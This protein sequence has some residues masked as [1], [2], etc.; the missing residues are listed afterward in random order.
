MQAFVTGGTGFVGA[1]LVEALTA[2]G[3]GARIL[4]RPR[5]TTTALAGLEYDEATGDILDPPDQLARLMEGCDWLFHAAAVADYWRQDKERLYRVNVGGV[6]NILQAARLAGVKRV[7]LTS[8]LASLGL[9]E[10]GRLLDESCQFNLRPDQFPYGHS[11][12]LAELEARQA[13]EAGLEVVIV[14]PSVILGPRD[15][16]QISGSFLLEA[17]QG[18]MRVIPPGGVNFVDVADVA[19][20]H[21]AAAARGR[22]GHRY[23]LGGHNLTYREA[24]TVISQVVGQ[25]PPRLR[26]PGWTLPLIGLAVAAMRRIVGSRLPVDASQVRLAGATLFADS[27]KARRELNL[28]QTP[29]ITTVQRTWQ[30]YQQQAQKRE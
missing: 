22:V 16:N 15:V 11:K 28:P 19:A 21:L 17:A 7:V 5:S 23:I 12:Y 25:P 1:N 26:L 27:G 24:A 14:N 9:P 3:I 6:K 10:A 4:R 13:V 18:R 30:W 29:F 20:G 2:Q 8:S